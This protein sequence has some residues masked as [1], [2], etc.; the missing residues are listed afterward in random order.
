MKASH[1]GC[2]LFFMCGF[3]AHVLAAPDTATGIF[4]PEFK[5]LR[6]TNSGGQLLPPVL[7]LGGGNSLTVEFDELAESRRYLRYRLIHCSANWQ[8]SALVESEYLNGFNQADVDDYAYSESTFA[9]YV[10]YRITVPSADMMPRLSGNYLLQ[11]YDSDEPDKILLQTRFMVSEQSAGLD[12]TVT[13]RTDLDYNARHQQLAVTANVDGAGVSD[14]F[15]DLRLVI[16][17][18]GSPAMTRSLQRP[19]RASGESAVW[20]HQ[21]PLIFP[22]GNEY[23]R[24]EMA[25]VHY[26]QRGVDHYEYA[27]PYYHAILQTDQKRSAS[28]YEYDQDQNGKF[29]VNE[30]SVADP[31]IQADYLVA[32][33]ELES[34]E[35]AE[36]I[37]LEG[38]LTQRRIDLDSRMAYDMRRGVYYKTLLLKQGLYNYRYVTAD[39]S[40]AA[41]E[42]NYYETVNEYL[43]LLYN[44]APGARYDRLIGSTVIYSGK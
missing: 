19:L 24:V 40:P 12:V 32:H 16:V 5:S 9:H 3:A 6:V 21:E 44:R 15:N 38:D 8:P 25:T 26:P 23:R 4:D 36:P 22:A 18:N 39:G 10:N 28:R 27:E 31:S 43:I 30:I 20:E 14:V 2:L 33:F 1:I 42:G 13:S 41:M 7:Q 17:Q 35:M 34:Q 11:V 37:F 29:F